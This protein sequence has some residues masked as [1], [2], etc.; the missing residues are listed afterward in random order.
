MWR[1]RFGR[2]FEP[3]VRQTA[4]LMM[5]MMM[6][7][8]Y[9]ETAIGD[10]QCAYRQGRSTVIRSS[11]YVKYPKNVTNMVQ[12]T[13]YHFINFKAAYDSIDRHRLYASVE[14]LSIPRKLIALIKATMKNTHCRIKIQNRFCEPINVKN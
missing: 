9:V 2:G 12:D 6:M 10:Y 3:V 13:I 11:L 7:M 1:D 5:M 4:G 8:P 14:Q